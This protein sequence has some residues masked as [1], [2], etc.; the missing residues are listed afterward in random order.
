MSKE[1]LAPKA[2]IPQ[3]QSSAEFRRLAHQRLEQI[4]TDMEARQEYG[5]AGV[6][7]TFQRG[8]A[9]LIRRTLDG[10]DRPTN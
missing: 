8:Q 6:E 3:D 5:T 2:A 10:T 9:C 1:R 7:V 4:F